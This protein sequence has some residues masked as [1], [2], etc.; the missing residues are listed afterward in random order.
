MSG[1]T[2]GGGNVDKDDRLVG[3]KPAIQQQLLSGAPRLGRRR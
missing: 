1:V 3:G 2:S